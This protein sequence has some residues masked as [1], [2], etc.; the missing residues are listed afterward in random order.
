MVHHEDAAGDI[1]FSH[2]CKN[3]GH[4]CDDGSVA[5]IALAKQ[6]DAWLRSF[7]EREQARIVE[8]DSNDRSSLLL[9]AC[10]DDSIGFSASPI[11]AACVASWP[12]STS[13]A[14]SPGESGMSMRNL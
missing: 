9:R 2:C 1:G 10:H 6:D 11:S 13:Q 14:A 8:V 7:S 12:R 3:V 4:P 5:P